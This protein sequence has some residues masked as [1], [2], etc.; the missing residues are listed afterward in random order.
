VVHQA[1]ALDATAATRYDIEENRTEIEAEPTN[2]AASP[3]IVLN[4]E[5]KNL[6]VA[7]R[8][9]FMSKQKW[10]CPPKS[11]DQPCEH[12][13]WQLKQYDYYRG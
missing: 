1:D 6:S 10:S 4:I 2:A 7:A 9:G 5:S 13:G 12:Q 3:M 11:Q 8:W